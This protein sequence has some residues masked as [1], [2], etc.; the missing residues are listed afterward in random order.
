MLVTVEEAKTKWCPY[1]RAPVFTKRYAI[2]INRGNDGDILKSCL[3]VGDGCMLWTP[4]ET[5]PTLGSCT[6]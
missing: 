3:C 4:D 1:V 5:L 6:A 2:T